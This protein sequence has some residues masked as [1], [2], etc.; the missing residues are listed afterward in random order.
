VPDAPPPPGHRRHVVRGALLAAV[1]V[2]VLFVFVYPTRTFL[3]QHDQVNKARAQL[4]LLR[5]ENA[6]LD[7][8]KQRL[9]QDDEIERIAREYYG[10]VKPGEIPFVILPAPTTTTTTSPP[11]TAPASTP[12]P[13]SS[14][15]PGP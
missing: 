11:A 9:N 2:G 12:P 4:D 7:A 8:E 15:K 1:L 3:D 6:K 10:L 13:P 14:T 5:S